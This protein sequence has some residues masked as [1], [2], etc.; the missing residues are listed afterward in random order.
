MSFEDRHRQS[1]MQSRS[2]DYCSMSSDVLV[3]WSAV[4]IEES[5][6]DWKK[7]EQQL[8]Q[9]IGLWR[10]SIGQ[11]DVQADESICTFHEDICLSRNRHTQSQDHQC[12]EDNVLEDVL[13]GMS[14]LYINIARAENQSTPRRKTSKWQGKQ[15]RLENKPAALDM[16]ATKY[17]YVCRK[18]SPP[19]N[20]HSSR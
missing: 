16:F 10:L 5:L 14:L 18:D 6:L 11:Q 8:L 19:N 20:K 13:A 2:T 12:Q 3:G 7:R 15:A 9:P 4:H 1:V 17:M